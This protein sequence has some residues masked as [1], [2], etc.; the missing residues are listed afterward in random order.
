MIIDFIMYSYVFG[1]FEKKVIIER[2]YIVNDYNIIVGVVDEKYGLISEIIDLE[3]VSR[4]NRILFYVN[5]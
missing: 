2:G 3:R 1:M 5:E 4:Y